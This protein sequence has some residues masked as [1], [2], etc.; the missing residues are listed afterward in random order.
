MCPGLYGLHFGRPEWL[1][2]VFSRKRR[3]G[4]VSLIG[5]DAQKE[6]Q[7]A[8]ERTRRARDT[9]AYVKYKRE[10]ARRVRST[11]ANSCNTRGKLHAGTRAQQIARENTRS[12]LQESHEPTCTRKLRMRKCTLIETYSLFKEAQWG[13]TQSAE[14][15]PFASAWSRLKNSVPLHGSNMSLFVL[16]GLPSAWISMVKVPKPKDTRC[17]YYFLRFE[18]LSLS[19]HVHQEALCGFR[20]QPCACMCLYM[21]RPLQTSR[22]LTAV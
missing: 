19:H 10:C 16:A 15:T 18:S 6:Q 14:M 4:I 21:L 9:R 12:K 20:F 17:V 8:K 11:G 1:G 3:E 2:R 13:Q 22:S 7:D 5:K